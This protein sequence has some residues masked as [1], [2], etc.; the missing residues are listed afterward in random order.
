M[1]SEASPL[2]TAVMYGG[3]DLRLQALGA[4]KPENL[5]LEHHRKS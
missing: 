4:R 2:Y 1:T 5:T 3:W